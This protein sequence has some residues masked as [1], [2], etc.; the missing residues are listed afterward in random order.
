MF[1]KVWS[2][3]LMKPGA[4]FAPRSRSFG[5]KGEILIFYFPRVI[6]G[7]ERGVADE[8][9][10]RL[11][12]GE[13]ALG[14][15]RPDGVGIGVAMRVQFLVGQRHVLSREWPELLCPVLLGG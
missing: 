4:P 11:G 9:A 6:H 10:E 7:V 13:L 15:E 1:P 14:V 2:N 12:A 5:R 8:E 3:R